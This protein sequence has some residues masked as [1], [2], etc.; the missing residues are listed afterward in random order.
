M[1]K[2][3][4][5]ADSQQRG[6]QTQELNSVSVAKDMSQ[7]RG[8]GATDALESLLLASEVCMLDRVRRNISLKDQRLTVWP[9]SWQLLSKESYQDNFPNIKLQTEHVSWNPNICIWIVFLL[10]INCFFFFTKILI[11]LWFCVLICSLIIYFSGY[12]YNQIVTNCPQI[13]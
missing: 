9:W 10:V 11:S 13:Q 4:V 8:M 7:R 1:W 3:T 6:C 5:Q 2:Q 12:W